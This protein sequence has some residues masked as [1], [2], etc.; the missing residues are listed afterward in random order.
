[1][2]VKSEADLGRS[3]GLHLLLH[4]LREHSSLNFQTLF[5]YLNAQLPEVKDGIRYAIPI[6]LDTVVV[7]LGPWSGYNVLAQ[8][9]TDELFFSPILLWPITIFFLPQGAIEL[10][11]CGLSLGVFTPE[12]YWGICKL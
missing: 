6:I 2:K 1:M 5:S 7:K 11:N 12:W 3:P 8:H 9:L 10:S 4:N